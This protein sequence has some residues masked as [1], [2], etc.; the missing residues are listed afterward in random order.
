MDIVRVSDTKTQSNDYK[1][2]RY[3]VLKTPLRYVIRW[4]DDTASVFSD[5]VANR[6]REIQRPSR[7]VLCAVLIWIHVIIMRVMRHRIVKCL[8]CTWRPRRRVSTNAWFVFRDSAGQTVLVFRSTA[9]SRFHRPVDQRERRK[10]EKRKLHVSDRVA[11]YKLQSSARSF[12]RVVRARRPFAGNPRHG[13]VRLVTPPRR[14]SR[15]A[16]LRDSHT[17]HFH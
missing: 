2:W 9:S 12:R 1:Y 11:R 17:P 4:C 5:S 16:L 14:R 6:Y 13:P 7:R 3:S 10:D 15:I 8:H